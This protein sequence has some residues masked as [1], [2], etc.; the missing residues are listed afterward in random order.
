MDTSFPPSQHPNAHRQ[1]QYH[2]SS[3]QPNSLPGLPGVEVANTETVFHHDLQSFQ[4]SYNPASQASP[5]APAAA[6]SVTGPNGAVNGG[7]GVG[8]VE[9]ALAQ[10]SQSLPRLRNHQG[11]QLQSSRK[12]LPRERQATSHNDQRR[13]R[14]GPRQQLE[15]HAGNVL[16]A[17]NHR[18]CTVPPQ[19]GLDDTPDGPPR[20][21]LED[22][23]QGM[24]SLTPRVEEMASHPSGGDED[25]GATTDGQ[26]GAKFVL[27]PPNLARWRQRLFDLEEMVALDQEE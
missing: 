4:H 5:A 2:E 17:T 11:E 19:E 25:D 13:Q 24:G 22:K 20:P 14:T 1:I 21:A 27:D 18:Q 8:D 12:H 23:V 26:A 16:D 10:P 3:F 9:P 6:A 15:Q 7:F